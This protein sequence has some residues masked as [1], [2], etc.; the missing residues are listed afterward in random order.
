MCVY[1]LIIFRYETGK[2]NVK[3]SFLKNRT[4]QKETETLYT[5][6]PFSCVL[7][8]IFLAFAGRFLSF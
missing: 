3:T 7:C 5:G 4:E 2:T 1:P 8:C 6:F